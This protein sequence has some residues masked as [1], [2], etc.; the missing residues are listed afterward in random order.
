MFAVG[1]HDGALRR[2][3][4]AYKFGGDRWRGPVLGRLLAGLL[5]ARPT[6]FEEYDR[7]V[8]VPAFTGPGARRRWDPVGEI[9]AT[10]AAIAGPTWVCEPAV[11]VKRAETPPMSGRSRR[12]RVAAAEGPL[13]RALAVPDPARV[14]GGR[15]LVVD[16][17][18]TEG[19]TLREVALA[20]L[21]AGA[22]EVAG[23]VLARRGACSSR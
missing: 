10:L 5:D 14:R 9:F 21:G 4:A 17:V 18:L 11:V 12:D 20:L 15:V 6:W 1:P 2:A 13:R 16:D 7:I 22:E 19:S 3:I 8:A 23:L